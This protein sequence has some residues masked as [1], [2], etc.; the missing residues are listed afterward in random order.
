MTAL[1]TH[2]RTITRHEVVTGSLEFVTAITK[3]IDNRMPSDDLVAIHQRRL[4]SSSASRALFCA[5]NQ[6]GVPKILVKSS[7]AQ[8]SKRS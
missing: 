2:R 6:N 7:A 1:V 8:Y 5:K 3:K 4:S